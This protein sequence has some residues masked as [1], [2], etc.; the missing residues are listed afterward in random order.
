MKYTFKRKNHMS[1]TKKNLSTTE[2]DKELFAELGIKPGEPNEFDGKTNEDLA[3]EQRRLDIALKQL[4]LSDRLETAAKKKRDRDAKRTEYAAKN[5]ALL[6]E[7][8]RRAAQMR[9]CSH[10]KGGAG[11][12]KGLP[13]EGGDSDMF[14]LLKHQMPSGFWEVWCQRCGAHWEPADPFTGRPATVIGDMTY[15]DAVL[16]R[17]DNHP[18]KSAV[19]KFEDNR[20][21]D[22][23]E[24]DRWKPAR[25]EDG[26]LAKDP[27]A[28]PPIK[29]GGVLQPSAPAAR[30]R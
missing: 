18:S 3:E 20:T 9:G 30:T 17:T 4:E 22:Q 29:E 7:I 14:A 15:K 26:S 13:P 25:N 27:Y 2:R 5:K 10:R 24:A 6:E 16:A 28:N 12:S 8:A 1:D 21:P 19:F 23:I 11:S